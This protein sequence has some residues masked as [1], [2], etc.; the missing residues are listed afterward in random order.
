MK[1]NIYL[2]IVIL[3]VVS[4]SNNNVQ[5]LKEASDITITP[6][7]LYKYEDFNN[8]GGEGYSFYVYKLND[9]EKKKILNAIQKNNICHTKQNYQQKNW[10]KNVLNKND[11]IQIT[12]GYYTK[13]K[14]L[15]KEQERLKEKF[16]SNKNYYCYYVKKIDNNIISIILLYID[17]K[18]NKLY[19]IKN[20]V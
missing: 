17:T 7:L 12:L 8:V 3:L 19:I 16:K 14:I 20:D 1:N 4:C 10:I 15:S 18:E 11:I 5:E 13:D 6:N 2:F 9:L